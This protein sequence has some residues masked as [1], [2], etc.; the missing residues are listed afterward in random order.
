MIEGESVTGGGSLPGRSM[1]TTLI[2]IRS[3]KPQLLAKTL[4]EQDT[5]IVARVERGMLV[6]DLR[7]VAPADDAAVRAALLSLTR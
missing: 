5:P 6:L 1:E 2:A 7:T 3:D 4:R